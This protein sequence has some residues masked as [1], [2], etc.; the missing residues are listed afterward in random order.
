[1]RWN[2]ETGTAGVFYHPSNNANGIKQDC[3][4]PLVA[5]EL[6]TRRIRRGEYDGT[7]VL[8]DKFDGTRCPTTSL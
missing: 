2:E 1:M 3:L 8:M 7:T 5:W 6:D 4:R